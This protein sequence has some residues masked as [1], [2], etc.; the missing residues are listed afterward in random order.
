MQKSLALLTTAADAIVTINMHGTLTGVNPA[1]S[2]MF[3]YTEQDMIDRAATI[4]P[5]SIKLIGPT[6][7][8]S[9]S[10]TPSLRPCPIG[11]FRKVSTPD[12][13]SRWLHVCARRLF[14]TDQERSRL[15]AIVD[16]VECS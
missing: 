16:D 9:H 4:R 8:S 5:E 7:F 6:F 3:G 1:T 12:T 10:P 2:Q 15:G 14:V 13:S 11:R